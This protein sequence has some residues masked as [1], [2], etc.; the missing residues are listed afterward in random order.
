MISN[1]KHIIFL[2]VLSFG[3][4]S[5]PFIVS[6]NTLSPES[7]APVVVPDQCGA[8]N[9]NGS[10]LSVITDPDT[11]AGNLYIF[12]TSVFATATSSDNTTLLDTISIPNAADEVFDL[13]DSSFGQYPNYLAL[14]SCSGGD[15]PL[16]IYIQYVPRQVLS[17][18][19]GS[20]ASSSSSLA[21]VT[22][23][24]AII[25]TLLFLIAIGYFYNQMT[26]KNSWF[27]DKYL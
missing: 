1:F 18:F 5:L 21:D 22:F 19:L 14:Y 26:D 10:Y 20:T 13:S 6:A 3:F 17:T 25:I 4:L 24:E 12:G 9:L 11:G 2:I 8:I 23:G 16:N 15:E 7:D 27:K